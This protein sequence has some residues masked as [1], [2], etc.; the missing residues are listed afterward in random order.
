MKDL[1]R[2]RFVTRHFHELRGLLQVPTG[3]FLLCGGAVFLVHSPLLGWLLVFF[4]M[5]VPLGVF[6]LSS[7]YYE[8]TFGHVERLPRDLPL[9]PDPLSI[10]SSAG[11]TLRLARQ[12][13]SHE[14]LRGSL[15]AAL[16]L[17]LFSTLRAINPTVT[18]R[19]GNVTE[20]QWMPFLLQA[21]YFL[22]G[23]AFLATWLRRE[24]R[25]SQAY[26]LV[27]AVLM[28][29][30]AALG[31]TEGLVFPL[32][33]NQGTG[34]A[35]TMILLPALHN[36]SVPQILYGAAVVL[37]GLLDHFQLVRRPTLAGGE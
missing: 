1:D 9:Q 5:P 15:V 10:Y 13:V 31:S 35:A 3:M 25:L 8:R 4:M 32:L 2:I 24:R 33:L 6:L 29:G 36:I 30:L 16:V 17:V 12:P 26:Y 23:M 27:F 11:T 14:W 34:R 19:W 22:F 20:P 37:A 18:V 28:L 21:M 7:W